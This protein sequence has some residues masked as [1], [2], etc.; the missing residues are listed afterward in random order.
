MSKY[1]PDPPWVFAVQVIQE[2]EEET[3]HTPDNIDAHDTHEIHENECEGQ[4]ETPAPQETKEA[5]EHSVDPNRSQYDSGNDEFPLH[6]FDE[7]VEVEE[8]DGDSNV[9]YICTT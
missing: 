4:E 8:S 5:P 3:P 7:Y 6:A 1:C 9:V 2:D